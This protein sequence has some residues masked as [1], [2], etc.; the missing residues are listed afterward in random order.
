MI[1][2]TGLPPTSYFINLRTKFGIP[3]RYKPET[4]TIFYATVFTVL[5]CTSPRLQVVD[6]YMCVEDSFSQILS[7]VY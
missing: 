2:K 6:N 7:Y 4:F 5:N 1:T 3:I